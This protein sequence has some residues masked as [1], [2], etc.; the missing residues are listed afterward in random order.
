MKEP[1]H[2]VQPLV[3]CG[4]VVRFKANALVCRL[5][6]FATEHGLGLN[7]LV[8][9]HWSKPFAREDWEQLYQLIG[10]SASGYGDVA[11]SVDD[12]SDEEAAIISHA[13]ADAADAEADHMVAE[14]KKQSG[15]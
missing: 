9:E 2:P 6:D 7:E 12:D 4:D 3:W 8:R 1:K 13:S 15:S 11:Y 14:R 10:Y 5:L